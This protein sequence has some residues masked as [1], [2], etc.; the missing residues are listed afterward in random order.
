MDI[1]DFTGGVTLAQIQSDFVANYEAAYLAL[2]G[3]SR[4]VQ[5]AQ[6][7]MLLIN[8]G[9]YMIYQQLLRV[10]SAALQ[11]L[12]QFATYPALDAIAKPFGVTRLLPQS[13]LVTINLILTPGHGALVIP[14]G[15]R[16]QSQD[17][18][19]TFFIQNPIP[20]GAT[21][22]LVSAIVMCDTPGVGGN[23][24]AIGT[25]I[26]ILDPQA[27]LSSIVN[28]DVSAGGSNAETD[29]GLRSRLYIASGAFSCA[30]PD[31]AY[32]SIAKSTSPLILDAKVN[33]GGG[34]LVN[35]YILVAGGVSA[36]ELLA[37]VTAKCNPKTVRPTSDTVTTFN[38]TVINYNV[39]IDVTV[40]GSVADSAALIIACQAAVQAE[41]T[42]NGNLLGIDTIKSKLEALAYLPGV[43]KATINSPAADIVVTN[44]EVGFC[45]GVVVNLIGFNYER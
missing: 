15:L 29:D 39:Q 25:I 32:I 7:E 5:P 16:V 34:G 24:Y 6:A 27:Y 40:N 8:S 28:T 42:A 37:A 44:T 17:G 18:L 1:P 10:Q 11:G 31:D 21:V 14:A 13:A 3:N 33:N 4:T 30:G 12:A 45:T 36:P 19:A 41:T 23:G 26:D 20:V 22:N 2:T 9:A 38:P 43:Y 35:I